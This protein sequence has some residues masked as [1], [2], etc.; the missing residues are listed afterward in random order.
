M[1]NRIYVLLKFSYQGEGEA[2]CI[3]P[4]LH[5]GTAT[6][7]DALLDL[8]EKHLT[9]TNV[10]SA[11]VSD[12]D[13]DEHAFYTTYKESFEQ[14]FH[15]GFKVQVMDTTTGK[16]SF[17]IKGVDDEALTAIQRMVQESHFD[18]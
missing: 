1:D 6:N 13:Q 3:M 16:T 8:V 4:G 18:A 15:H 5:C 12:N 2:D 14:D 9:L 10:K 17:L 7:L 11:W